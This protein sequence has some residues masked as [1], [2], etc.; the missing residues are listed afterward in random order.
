MLYLE[1]AGTKKGRGR[2]K[3]MRSRRRSSP[4]I[5]ESAK[6]D[7]RQKLKEVGIDDENKASMDEC[8]NVRYLRMN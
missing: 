7:H 3:E 4:Y 1:G 8:N 6:I 2:K 5:T